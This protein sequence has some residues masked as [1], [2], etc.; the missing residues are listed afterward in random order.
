MAFIGTRLV[1]RSALGDAS[2]VPQSERRV[3][4]RG[5]LIESR[6]RDRMAEKAKIRVFM[7]IPERREWEFEG[8]VAVWRLLEKIGVNPE[9]VLVIR[10]GDLMTPDEMAESG[11]VIEVRSAISGGCP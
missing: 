11:M 3:P 8:R 7:T 5:L 1:G 2:G 9:S 4:A 10:D 6:Q